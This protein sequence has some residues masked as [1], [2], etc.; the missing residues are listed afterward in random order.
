M[1]GSHRVANARTAMRT[2]VY[3]RMRRH[4]AVGST[5]NA[6]GVAEG[7]TVLR[8]MRIANVRR[9][10]V[11]RTRTAAFSEQATVEEIPAG[12]NV[13]RSRVPVVSA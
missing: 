7:R 10:A 3:G 8:E 12:S 9:V 13:S 4:A 6:A 5:K 2:P 1:A 11:T